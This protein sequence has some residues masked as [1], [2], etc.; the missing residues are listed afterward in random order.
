MPT[1]V[2]HTPF[3]IDRQ[4]RA[5]SGIRPWRMMDA[6]AALGYEVLDVTGTPAERRR[7][8]RA[9]A[10]RLREGQKID[11]LYSEC[12]TIPTMLAGAR[13]LPPHPVLDPALFSLVR[14][15]GVPTGLFYRDMYWAFEDYEAS[16]GRPLATL[17]RAVYHY[18]LAW[19]RRL[20]DILFL[21]SAQMGHYVPV[22]PPDRM[23]P[24]PPGG[25]VV[26]DHVPG[27]GLRLLYVGA[28]GGH[29]RLQECVRAVA[30]APREVTLTICTHESQW[31]AARADYEPLMDDR[32]RVVHRSGEG[33]EA[34]YREAEAGVLLVE[35]NQYREFAAPVKL[36][37]YLGHGLPVLATAGTLAGDLVA[38]RDCGWTLPYDA[39]AIGSRLIA[40]AADPAQVERARTRTREVRADHTWEARAQRVA[41]VLGAVRHD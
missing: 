6:F 23:E 26:D 36:F 35:A 39:G 29:Y 30:A 1:M 9:L 37:E 11:F 24:L 5:A 22:F 17:M 19:Y 31:E 3:P 21:P 7:R 10:R 25:V 13:H 12:A 27:E 2:F 33:L 18:D 40:L 14:R 20:V 34:L 38:S 15:H 16:V 41:D 28:L 8:V 32:V 4:A